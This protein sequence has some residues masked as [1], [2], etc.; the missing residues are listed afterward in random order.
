MSRIIWIS[1]L[2][3][4]LAA[5]PRVVTSVP[6]NTAPA[7][8]YTWNSESLVWSTVLIWTERPTGLT[9]TSGVLIDKEKRRVLAARHA[10]E[11]SADAGKDTGLM[12][13]IYVVWP[14]PAG[15][16][17]G[18]LNTSD[19]YFQAMRQRRIPQAKVIAQDLSRDLV[20]LEAGSAPPSQT[21]ALDLHL[22]SVSPGTSVLGV[23]QPFTRGNLWQP[24]TARIESSAF[25]RLSYAQRGHEVALYLAHTE[26]N[27]EFGF[28]GSPLVMPHSG[29]LVGMLLA[30]QLDKPFS[31][32]LI[33]SQEIHRF[34]TI[35]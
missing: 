12:E 32:A 23:A 31:F 29:K 21:R 18:V 1:L 13:T 11:K 33:N 9:L 17:A 15:D 27:I 4:P 2:F 8:L 20:L 16:G 28:S 35:E 7:L 22:D 25:R 34:L 5:I 19:K 6:H 10:L 14:E 30:A 24:F 26:Q 3:L